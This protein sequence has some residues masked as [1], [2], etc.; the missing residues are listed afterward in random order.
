[1]L[2]L[3]AR[4]KKI[5]TDILKKHIPDQEVRAFGS[6]VRGTA[7]TTSDLD[8]VIINQGKIEK[9]VLIDLKEAFDN[10]LL[11]IKIDIVF[12][13]DLPETFRKNIDKHHEIIQKAG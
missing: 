10:S 8:L 11:D 13:N 6:R 12:W 3:D 2:D 4:Q 5:V 9:N 1:M 7:R